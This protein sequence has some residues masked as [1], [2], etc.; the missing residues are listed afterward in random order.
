MSTALKISTDEIRWDVR[1]PMNR[2]ELRLQ[3]R[4]SIKMTIL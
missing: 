1:R 3:Q 2:A 4:R